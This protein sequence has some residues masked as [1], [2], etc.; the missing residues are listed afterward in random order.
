MWLLQVAVH[1][2]SDTEASLDVIIVGFC[3]LQCDGQSDRC[4]CSAPR[5]LRDRRESIK[6]SRYH[7]C[8]WNYGTTRTEG[9]ARIVTTSTSAL[10]TGAG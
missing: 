2:D 3:N 1:L 7:H 4:H 9:D 6:P 8:L 5:I 10:S